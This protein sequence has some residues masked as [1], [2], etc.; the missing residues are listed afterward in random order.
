MTALS[1]CVLRGCRIEVVEREVPAEFQETVNKKRSE[2]VGQWSVTWHCVFHWNI[3]RYLFR[4]YPSP[5]LLIR[6]GSKCWW[7][8]GRAVPVGHPAHSRWAQGTAVLAVKDLQFS[9]K[10][11]NP[12]PPTLHDVQKIYYVMISWFL[13]FPPPPPPPPPTKLSWGW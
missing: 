10:P 5:F 7:S 13:W 3:R 8:S 2:L 1:T 6:A 11:W 4:N 12:P 9:L